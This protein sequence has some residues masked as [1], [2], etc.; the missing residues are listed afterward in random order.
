MQ[1]IDG[2]LAAIG[3]LVAPI[4]NGLTAL[5]GAF[6][7][8]D[9]AKAIV[10]AVLYAIAMFVFQAIAPSLRNALLRF[11]FLAL[12]IFVITVGVIASDDHI[13]R[14]SFMFGPYVE[15]IEKYF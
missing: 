9:I 5:L 7:A 10:V 1:I 15:F 12:V 13:T 2:I 14:D 8:V 3:L 11:V 6:M 4:I